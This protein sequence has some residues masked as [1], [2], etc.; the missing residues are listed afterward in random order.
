M[1]KLYS[2]LAVGALAVL[3][4]SC[5]MEA[6]VPVDDGELA[7]YEAPL[8]P[9][10][11]PNG[12]HIVVLVAGA[13]PVRAAHSAGAAPVHVYRHALRGFS[14]PLPA[15]AL[16]HLRSNP[17][18]LFIQPDTTVE[19]VAQILPEGVD[20]IDTD[21]NPTANIDGNHAEI[22]VDVAVIDTGVDL[23]HPDLNVA[24]GVAYAGNS[25]KGGDDDEGHGSHVAGTIAAMDNNIG[26]V[27]VAPGARIWAVKVLDRDGSG[28]LSDVIAGVD[29]VTANSDIIEV[30]NMSLSGA[31]SD[32]TDG[33]NCLDSQ[34]AY[35]L[36]ICNSVH[37]G[38]VYVVAAGNASSD[39]ATRQPAAYDEVITV[40]A[41]A[42]FDGQPGGAGSGNYAFSSCTENVDDSFACFSNYGHDVDIMAPG[43]G[44][45]STYYRGGYADSSGTSMASPHVAGA[46]ALYIA[47]H[48]RAYDYNGV[49]AIRQALID[50][51]DP[52][53]CDTPNGVCTDDPDG[54]QEPLLY[55][56]GAGCTVDAE[57]DDLNECTDDFCDAGT[58]LFAEVAEDTVCDG[59]TGICC[60]GACSAPACDGA[61]DCGDGSDCTTDTCLNPGTCAAACDNTGA[62]DGTVCASGE[63]C[64]GVCCGDLCCDGQCT[65]ADCNSNS[66]CGDGQGCTADVCLSAGTCAAACDN[67]WP[68]CG[69]SDSCCGP[70]CS[71]GDDGDCGPVC[72]APRAACSSNSDCCSGSC[73]KNGTCR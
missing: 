32:D 27:G 35:H 42:D 41:L 54:I 58:C 73:K 2:L 12:R 47:E 65:A 38:V 19:A 29:W 63:C 53:P 3:A 5:V 61:A 68:A 30:A 25:R 33:G 52:A 9:G 51:G 17:N 39:A 69:I 1:S 23:D 48:G 46:V 26:V 64:G 8:L 22:P 67:T 10:T 4:V 70:D 72:G 13:D 21:L 34:D 55:V 44:I 66:D 36:A 20:R 45:Y 11:P 14:A 28:Y 24:G 31:G 59:G 18:V 15:P 50:A 43:V 16:A 56:G 71:A 37:A 62:P 7:T 57:C 60:G 40:S 49:M 6:P